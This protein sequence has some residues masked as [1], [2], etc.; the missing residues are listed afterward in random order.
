MI[1]AELQVRSL[2]GEMKILNDEVLSELHGR[3]RSAGHNI[4]GKSLYDGAFLIDLSN[5]RSV[6]VDP[7]ERVAVVEPG[8]T[9][10]DV[11]HE[12][13]AYGLAYRY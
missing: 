7:Q 9:L 12:T 5:I 13:Q 10:G 11:D 1:M 2:D 6:R 4:A 3:V 8:A